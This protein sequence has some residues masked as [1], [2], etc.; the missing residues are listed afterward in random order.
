MSAVRKLD[1]LTEEEFLRGEEL[2]DLPNEFVDG[3]VIAM[4][5]PTD[6]HE[7]IVLNLAAALNEHLGSHPCRV[8]AGR[9]KLRM[10]YL[11]RLAHYVPDVMVACDKEPA[12]RKFR[13]FPVLL[14]EVL[15]PTTEGTD[16]REKMFAYL[17]IEGLNHYIIIAQD[18]V[19]ITIYRRTESG[20]EIETLNSLD[21]VLRAPDLG[22]AMPVARLYKNAKLG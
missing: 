7:T 6:T 18:K 5:S 19:E 3:K 21:D 10:K 13:E 12:D 14:V 9:M 16:I 11:N 4:A 8:F 17:T 15:S 22:F 2:C 20:W 1:H